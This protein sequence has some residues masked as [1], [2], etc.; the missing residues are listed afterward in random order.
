MEGP[1]GRIIGI[2]ELMEKAGLD[3]ASKEDFARTM[4]WLRARKIPFASIGRAVRGRARGVLIL[5]DHLE[6]AIGRRRG[7]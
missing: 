7:E 2:R 1:W 3:P 5:G 6:A 4:N